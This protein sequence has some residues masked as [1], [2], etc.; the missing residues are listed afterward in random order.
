MKNI[1]K[2]F[3]GIGS[4]CLLLFGLLGPFLTFSGSEKPNW[5][6]ILI[7]TTIFS[8]MGILGFI[9]LIIAAKRKRAA[10]TILLTLAVIIIWLGLFLLSKLGFET[11]SF[12][13]IIWWIACLFI[14]IGGFL[15]LVGNYA[16]SGKDS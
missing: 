10:S 8:S 4:G 3:V 11:T 13:G 1:A 9:S 6:A 12:F 15:V 2:I 16:K 14:T 7:A 5:I